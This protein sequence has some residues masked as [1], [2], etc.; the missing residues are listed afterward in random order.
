M[1]GMRVVHAIRSAKFAGVEQ[2]V[3]RLAIAQAGAGHQVHVIGGD[4]AHMAASLAAAG[5]GFEPATQTAQLATALRRCTASTD[6]INTHMSA[7]DAAAV[8]AFAGRPRPTVVSTRH[9][10]R[11]RGRFRLFP[12]DPYMRLVVD[13]EIS[14]SAAV[15]RAI[16]TPST[17]VHPGVPLA[18]PQDRERDRSVLV[19]QRL[20]PEKQTMLA[21]EAFAR[22]GLPSDG[23]RLD[24]AGSGAEEESVARAASA[25]NDRAR[26]LGFRDAVPQLMAA[27]G[28]LLAPTPIEAL[29]LTVLE[30]MACGLPVVAAAAGGHLE[31]MGQLDERALF[32]AGDAAAAAQSLRSLADDPEGRRRL[33]E[34]ERQ[35]AAGDF[36]IESQVSKTDAVYRAAA[37]ARMKRGEP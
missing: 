1:S 16:G 4:P 30:A 8:L 13:A 11:R 28:I 14:V 36:S 5:V 26:M 10:P 33:G 20:Q 18:P 17:V 32:R 19:V 2:F 3:R 7:A 27:A 24:I 9:F 37:A 15:A 34:A 23:W 31:T 35:R 29:G 21:V 6:V 22:S 12:L 25:L